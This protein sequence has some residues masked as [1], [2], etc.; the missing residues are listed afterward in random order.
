M[1]RLVYFKL[2]A[3]SSLCCLLFHAFVISSDIH[4]DVITTNDIRGV[5]EPQK[6]NFMNPNYPPDIIGGA[7]FANYLNKLSKKKNFLLLDAGNFFRG[8]TLGMADSGR[9]MIKW[10]NKNNY[11]ALVPGQEDFIFGIENINIL[12][13]NADFPFLASNIK[14]SGNTSLSANIKP[15][16]IKEVDG[17]NIGIIGIVDPKISELSLSS[18]MS[19]LEILNPLHILHEKITALKQMGADII[20]LLTSMGIPYDRD[21]KYKEF[22]DNVSQITSEGWTP[23]NTLE[24]G[25]FAHGADV[26]VSGGVS[27]GYPQPWYDPYSH[28]YSFQNY[29]GG[30]EFGHFIIKTDSES[31]LFTGFNFAVD[32]RIG[33]TIL[34]DDFIPDIESKNWIEN[35]KRLLTYTPNLVIDKVIDRNDSKKNDWNIPKLGTD[36]GFEI[37]TWNWEFFPTAADSTINALTEII[38]DLDIDIIAIQEIRKMSYFEDLMNNLPMYDAVLSQNSSFLHQAI[39]Y[40]HNDFDAISTKELFIDNDYN[41]AGRPPL[42]S[43]FKDRVT[44]NIINV[45]NIHMK[46]CDSGLERR[47]KASKMLHE[48]IYNNEKLND[49]WIVLGDWNDDLKDEVGEHCF[50]PFLDNQNFKFVTESIVYDYDQASYPKAP[51][52]SFLDHILISTNLINDNDY[53]IRTVPIDKMMGGYDIYEYYISDHLPV[54]LQIPDNIH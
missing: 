31:K 46:C 12:A 1:S 28:V 18:N 47:K 20:V 42:Q 36:I 51:Y 38:D 9:T 23:S 43:T 16:I 45:I 44:G 19:G 4:I 41:F 37:M 33:Q 22:L 53:Q 50:E 39:I 7:G 24:L 32:G 5:I 26:I 11:D 17:I 6:A 15:F 25:Y 27:K 30:T 34:A 40:K 49:N 2:T 52:H 14:S 3:K 21:K 48:Y 8:S 13:D 10:M 29:G 35:Q 54:L